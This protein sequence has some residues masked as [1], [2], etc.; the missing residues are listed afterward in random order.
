MR[1]EPCP[2]CGAAPNAPC[3]TPLG[4]ELPGRHDDP[5]DEGEPRVD[6]NWPADCER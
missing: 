5:D 6:T 4:Y 1:R 2:V 3:R